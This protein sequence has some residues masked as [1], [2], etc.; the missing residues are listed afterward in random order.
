MVVLGNSDALAEA[1]SRINPGAGGPGNLPAATVPSAPLFAGRRHV[2][3]CIEC[4]DSCATKSP[5]GVMLVARL[6]VKVGTLKALFA[7]SGN[8]CA[9]PE[10]DRL[11]AAKGQV[12]CSDICHIRAA[13]RGGPRY[14]SRQTDEQRRE[15]DNLILF[16]PTHHRMVD[17]DDD[18]TVEMLTD[19]KREHEERYR[20]WVHDRLDYER[21]RRQLSRKRPSP[22][23]GK[24]PVPDSPCLERIAQN[25]FEFG[26]EWGPFVG[27]EQ[28]LARLGAFL[29]DSRRFAWWFLAGGSGQGKSRLALELLSNHAPDWEG[30]FLREIG[31]LSWWEGWHPNEQTLFVV[32]DVLPYPE[33]LGAWIERF[34][35]RMPEWEHCVRVL[36]IERA[37]DHSWKQRF[38]TP[39]GSGSKRTK[40]IE[41]ARFDEALT[42]SRHTDEE[43]IE[44]ASCFVGNHGAPSVSREALAEAIPELGD[45][46]NA[47]MAAFLGDLISVDLSTARAGKL[48]LIQGMLDRERNK[49]WRVRGVNERDEALLALSTLTAGMTSEQFAGLEEGELFPDKV[50]ES[51]SRQSFLSGGANDELRPLRPEILGNLFLLDTLYDDQGIF[52]RRRR[53][54][55]LSL[56]WSLQPDRVSTTI[57]RAVADFPG[58]PAVR[59][60]LGFPRRDEADVSVIPWSWAAMNVVTNCGLAGNLDA[61]R[62]AYCRLSDLRAANPHE[63]VAAAWEWATS[64]LASVESGA[65][66]IDHARRLFGSLV[67]QLGRTGDSRRTRHVVV[68]T[69]TNLIFDLGRSGLLAEAKELSQ[70]QASIAASDPSH[71]EL[72]HNFARGAVELFHFLSLYGLWDPSMPGVFQQLARRWPRDPVISRTL[73][74][75]RS[76]PSPVALIGDA[77]V[78]CGHSAFGDYNELAPLRTSPLQRARAVDCV[79]CDEWQPAF[80]VPPGIEGVSGVSKWGRYSAKCST[81]GMIR[82]PDHCD[83]MTDPREPPRSSAGEGPTLFPHCPV[84]SIQ[85]SRFPTAE[86]QLPHYM[87]GEGDERRS[88]ES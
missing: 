2:V 15:F 19:W 14:D 8:V 79:D 20:N 42:L 77:V 65:D 54:R 81:C 60:L 86:E 67:E 44:I 5:S 26:S 55:L 50:T 29:H 30:A 25:R 51:L 28:E 38:L 45:R 78:W 72:V 73:E 69:A 58:H 17:Q 16:C 63:A 57:S 22:Q 43:L 12:G 32:D 3:G 49:R 39:T 66:Q 47:Q 61:A 48:G 80:S 27:R 11:L 56:A 53:D 35:Q 6:R 33:T 1:P 24:G 76:V 74:T 59:D 36:L 68:W 88:L 4:R 13:N 37:E 46:R 52:H 75:V 21:L 84:C 71:R 40:H 62:E 70:L 23:S 9:Y 82:C 7:L 41:S 87:G 34:S 31:D 18:V 83:W 10:C 64:N 85:M